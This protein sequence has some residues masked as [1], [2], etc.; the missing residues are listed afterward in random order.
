MNLQVRT[1]VNPEAPME[2]APEGE[3]PVTFIFE[4]KMLGVRAGMGSCAGRDNCASEQRG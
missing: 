4:K 3:S 2:L 1:L